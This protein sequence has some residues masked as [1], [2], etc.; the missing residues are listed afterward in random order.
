MPKRFKQFIGLVLAVSLLGG[1]SLI[2]GCGPYQEAKVAPP[3]TPKPR[4]AQYKPPLRGETAPS[5]ALRHLTPMGPIGRH[6]LQSIK[7][8]KQ[9]LVARQT[10]LQ[11]RIRRL[12]SRLPRTPPPY[13]INAGDIIEIVY[14]MM[15]VPQK[16]ARYRLEVQD[17]LRIEFFVHRELN[18]QVSIR[19]DGRIS[20]PLVGDVYAAGLTSDELRD[21]LTRMYGGYVLNPRL[22]VYLVRFNVKID[23]LKRSITTAARGQSKIVPVRPDGRISLPLIGD[24]MAAGL[25]VPQLRADIIRRYKP[26]VENLD[27]TVIVKNLQAPRIYIHGEVTRPG[28]IIITG[29][30]PLS[31]IISRAQG[32]NRTADPSRILILRRRTDNPED[33]RPLAMRVNYRAVMNGDASRDIMLVQNDL[34]YVPRKDQ[35]KVYVLGEVVTPGIVTFDRSLTVSQAIAAAR[36]HTVRARLDSV[37]VL[38]RVPGQR[39][40]AFRVDYEDVIKNGNVA[41][42]IQLRSNDVVYV[43]KSFIAKVNDFINQ[44]FTRGVYALF[45]AGS[46]LQFLLDLDTI[47]HLHRRSYQF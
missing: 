40:T 31:T 23:E 24:V 21:K 11:R 35:N 39:P 14:H 13:R 47:M 1:F 17:V 9:G 41:K 32:F 30:T 5:P 45:P 33:T 4:S 18:R 26:L 7:N 3:Q 38:R 37:L 22:T 46:S 34:V 19:S 42:D 27:V 29:P 20:L 12:T 43:P 2:L 8:L 25:T 6:F 36:G 15:Y 44:W 10:A 28:E 16:K